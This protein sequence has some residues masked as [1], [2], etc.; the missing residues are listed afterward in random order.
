[1]P[2]KKIIGIGNAI[3]DLVCK[4]DE[5]FL[6][7]HNLAKNSMSLIDDETAEIMSILKPRKITS[8]GSVG[9][10]IATLA[11]LG[12][13]SAFI[14]KVCDDVFGKKYIEEIEKTSAKFL[15]K[16]FS[17]NPSAKS[18]VLVTD[19]A[20]RTMCTYLGCASE[21]TEDDLEDEMFQDAV[22]LF[23]EGY[24]WDSEVTILA[25]K[26]AIKLAKQNNVKVAFSLSD[27][28]CV[29]R[30]KKDFIKL[31]KNDIDI[32]F[33]N[34]NEV[35]ELTSEINFSAKKFQEL[36]KSNT[37]LI[38]AITMSENGCVI[39]DKGKY[40]EIA[41]ENVANLVDTTGAGDAFAAGFLYG[42]VN[43]LDSEKSAKIGNALAGKVIQK[44]G[45]RFEKEELEF[46]AALFTS[47]TTA[48]TPE[49]D[50]TKTATTSTNT[51]EKN[52]AV[53]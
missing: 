1:M 32:L 31:I 49:P 14:G 15:T 16:N 22:I 27:S 19:D 44:I 41:T 34:K 18:F 17:K 20:S 10:S 39:F 51:P 13:E 11:M 2:S 6:D 12:I 25:L 45:A 23:L 33:A 43:K 28:F 53:E 8:G 24:L 3:V 5:E 48:A 29:L 37:N 50:A 7:L 38:A 30:H 40:L 47:L 26:K 36:F 46:F 35:L 4:A 9:N 42:L 52:D 21:I